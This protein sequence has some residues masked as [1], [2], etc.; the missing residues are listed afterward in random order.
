LAYVANVAT[1]AFVVLILIF[2]AKGRFF[3]EK[4]FLY[5]PTGRRY[6]FRLPNNHVALG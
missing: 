4:R 6:L 2:F 1:V 3:I 5:Y